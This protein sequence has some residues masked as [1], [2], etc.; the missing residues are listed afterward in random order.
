MGNSFGARPRKRRVVIQGLRSSGVSSVLRSLNLG[1]VHVANP[2]ANFFLEVV[3]FKNCVFS[4]WTT[5][6]ASQW[7]YFYKNADA[8]IFVVDASSE[9][10]LEAAKK[11]L[12]RILLGDD[13]L[14]SAK[15]LILANKQDKG[16]FDANDVT[17]KLELFKLPQEWHVQPTVAI[18]GGR[19]LLEGLDWLSAALANTP[20][21]DDDD[22]C[23]KT[24]LQMLLG[25]TK[26]NHFI[27]R[28]SELA[29]CWPNN[30]KR[31]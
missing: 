4:A 31:T 10:D 24:P 25:T 28:V 14:D 27:T 17:Q 21:K 29:D 19:G 16:L 1:R 5:G 23:L 8:L 2:S 11:V 3:T 22:L 9:A 20:D 30:S 18:D 7:A 6:E 15:I 12:R 13:A 26:A